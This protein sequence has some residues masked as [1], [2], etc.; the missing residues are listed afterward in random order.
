LNIVSAILG[1]TASN[2]GWGIAARIVTITC[3][4]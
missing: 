4:L 1:I 3:P 2:G